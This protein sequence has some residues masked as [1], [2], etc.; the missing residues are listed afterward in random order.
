MGLVTGEGLEVR[1]CDEL[2]ID[3]HFLEAGLSGGGGIFLVEAFAGFENGGEE[4]KG[5]VFF[6]ELAE[7]F[8]D[9]FGGL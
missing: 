9:G 8:T 5:G 4:A 2:A 3:E 6:E 7:L 1:G